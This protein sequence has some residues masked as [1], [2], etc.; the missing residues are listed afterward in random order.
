MSKSSMFVSLLLI[1]MALPAC[2]DDESE[3][4]T[5]ASTSGLSEG[6]SPGGTTMGSG[7]TSSGTSGASSDA[8]GS[9]STTTT[10]STSSDSGTSAGSDTSEAPVCNPK[11]VEEPNNSEQT[12]TQ[13]P[14]ITD[15]DGAG[16]WI[17]S[18]LAGDKDE[19][20]FMYKGTDVAFAYVDPTGE[21]YAEMKIR[22]CVFVECVAGET[23]PFECSNSI[24]AV[25]PEGRMGCCS[26]SE[27]AFVSI[28]LYCDNDGDDNAYVYMRV[29]RG[30]ADE[31]VPYD[32]FY[33]Y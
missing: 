32:I 27:D 29:D 12:A 11:D 14:N 19:D 23:L 5:E 3:G 4:A 10:G 16:D 31:C 22:L 17:E 6:T 9:T 33:H 28:D 30:Y 24:D 25:S 2:S 18:I 15:E 21:L 1:G 20:W 8:T 13:L 7:G 26:T